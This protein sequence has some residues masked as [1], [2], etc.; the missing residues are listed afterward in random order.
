MQ[1]ESL[2]PSAGDSLIDN[3]AD[4]LMAQALVPEAGLEELVSG[5]CTRLAAA[6]IPLWRGQVAF[7]TLHP[8]FEAMAHTWRRDTGIKT[9]GFEHRPDGAPDGFRESAYYYMIENRVPFL[10]R[11]LTGEEAMLDFP[12]LEEFRD[13]GATDYLGYVVA[14][15][16]AGTDGIVGS[17]STDR[18]SGF[19]ERDIRS[20]MRIQSRLAVACK[21]T[22]KEQIAENIVTT[23]L[24]RNTGRRVLAGHIKRGDRETIHAVIWYSDLRSSTRLAHS[25][26]PDDYLAALNSYF[27]CTAGAVMEAGGEVLL[28]IGDA[29][30][31][32]FPIG[33]G[34]ATEAEACAAAVDAARA[35]ESRVERLNRERAAALDFGI[36][37]HVGDVMYGNI[38]VPDRLQ[39]TVVG[40]A[41]NEV[42]RL[43]NLNKSLRRRVLAT[44]QFAQNLDIPWEPMGTHELL[45][46]G[47]PLE[48][49]ALPEAAAS[50]DT[51]RVA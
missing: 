51:T 2:R 29:V 17:W 44:G 49:F 4:W 34:G 20:L 37:L 31:A 43:Q 46:V 38:G 42:A 45:G 23:Y 19:S 11:R 12:M 7:R 48:V 40:Q 8:L 3:V 10:R 39:F 1:I 15:N 35:S 30:L 25:L 9:V 32:I 5:C 27:E 47:A 41:A 22:I 16:E 50:T 33:D 28:L 36:D 13:Q 21:V 14:F 26:A 24:G 6:G 18:S